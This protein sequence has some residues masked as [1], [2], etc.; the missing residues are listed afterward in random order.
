MVSQTDQYPSTAVA[1]TQV[2]EMPYQ[3]Q[4]V[5]EVLLKIQQSAESIAAVP[6]HI[7]KRSS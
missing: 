4:Q 1:K 2:L 7:E 6:E 5:P 3:Q